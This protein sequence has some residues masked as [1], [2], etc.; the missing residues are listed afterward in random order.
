MLCLK[1]IPT[2]LFDTVDDSISPGTASKSLGASYK[3]ILFASDVMNY[4]YC[5][6]V[7]KENGLWHIC[8][9]GGSVQIRE[10]NP[11][12]N[13]Q[14][15]EQVVSSLHK[16]MVRHYKNIEVKKAEAG[17]KGGLVNEKISSELKMASRLQSRV[18][19]EEGKLFDSV[20]CAD[21]EKVGVA[22]APAKN[23]KVQ[24]CVGIVGLQSLD[25]KKSCSETG[26]IERNKENGGGFVHEQC[27]GVK[28]KS[29]KRIWQI[30]KEYAANFKD[31]LK[32]M[33]KNELS[34][35]DGKLFADFSKCSYGLLNDNGINLR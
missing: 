33:V 14:W 27:F 7:D 29:E 19:W 20:T 5:A 13:K 11:F 26:G 30:V 17:S 1:N 15:Y 4:K 35:A 28:M 18:N 22:R 34:P 23:L 21:G 31:V 8:L 12:I 6:S 3:A 24:S 16:K 25:H 2:E 32:L 10:E 9:Q